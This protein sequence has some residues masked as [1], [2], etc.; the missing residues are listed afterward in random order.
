MS[1]SRTPSALQTAPAAAVVDRDVARDLDLARLLV[2]LDLAAVGAERED[3]VRRVEEHGLV[4]PG[5]DPLGHPERL[6]RAER[7]LLHGDALV[8]AALHRERAAR[9]L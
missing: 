1:M 9:E 7:D 5:R 6:P 3:A 4:K 2:D 8:G